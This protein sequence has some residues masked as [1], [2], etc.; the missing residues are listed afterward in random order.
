V[1][2]P[3]V[4]AESLSQLQ[5]IVHWW[6]NDNISDAPLL[7][8][9]T[10][11]NWGRIGKVLQALAAFFVLVDIIGSSELRR[12]AERIKGLALDA[13]TMRINN[14][15]VDL[16]ADTLFDW[17]APSLLFRLDRLSR[18]PVRLGRR[19]RRSIVGGRKTRPT[20]PLRFGLYLRI[21]LCS[22]FGKRRKTAW[23]NRFFPARAN[24]PPGYE[25]WVIRA[26]GV[27]AAVVALC[28]A[29]EASPAVSEWRWDD[30]LVLAIV[31]V[32]V[33]AMSA[34]M[35]L[36]LLT[37]LVSFFLMAVGSLFN[38]FND[39]LIDPIVYILE[40]QKNES[41]L[42]VISLALFAV[43]FYFDLLAS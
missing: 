27:I 25:R 34:G 38:L 29:V 31:M 1:A 19:L 23:R 17:L 16:L 12:F 30:V 24:V 28:V 18:L 32:P 13:R 40:H 43:G 5:A 21:A 22:N 6:K 9:V 3:A 41:L 14:T 11:R 10:V 33:W 35:L 42:K 2:E 26:V 7:F 39:I 37:F 20:A 36:L 15:G 4:I 8:G